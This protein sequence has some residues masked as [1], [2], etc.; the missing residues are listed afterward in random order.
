VYGSW[1]NTRLVTPGP[2]YPNPGRESGIPVNRKSGTYGS[3][4]S[5]GLVH[6]ELIIKAARIT[7]VNLLLYIGR[8]RRLCILSPKIYIAMF[9]VNEAVDQAVHANVWCVEYEI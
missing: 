5:V 7:Y 1:Q 3:L 4:D 6:P 2:F 8:L 9:L